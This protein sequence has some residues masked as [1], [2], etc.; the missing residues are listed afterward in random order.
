MKQSSLSGLLLWCIRV[1][2]LIGGGMENTLYQ[3]VFK[4]A[5]H[6]TCVGHHRSRYVFDIS[7]TGGRESRLTWEFDRNTVKA[8]AAWIREKAAEQNGKQCNLP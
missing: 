3:R 7:D 6:C 2:I 5:F 4:E 8:Y 1:Y